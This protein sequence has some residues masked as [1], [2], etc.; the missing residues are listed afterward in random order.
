MSISSP[1]IGSNLDVNGIVS[2]LMSVESQP[3]TLLDQK[4]ASYQSELSAYG[5]LRGAL[6]SFQASLASLNNTSSYNSLSS[7]VA[8]PTVLTATASSTA[9]VGTNSIQVN[10]L[11]Q[12]QKIL[13]TGYSTTSAT[14]GTGTLTFQFGT[15]AG[16]TLT[17]GV[18]TG[19]SFTLNA[20]K[21]S[22]AVTIDSAHNTLSGIRDAVNAAN[23]GVSASIINDG[24][25][26]GNRLV[27]TSNDSGAANSLKISTTDPSLSPVFA[28]D[29]AG[30][31]NMTQTVIAQD[32]SLVVDGV[33][34]TKSSNTIT[35]A[36]QGVTLNLLKTN[37]GTPTTLTTSRSTSAISK[38]VQSFVD[39]Y[40]A[41]NKT[42]SGLTSYD[43][44]T[45]QGGV[46]LGDFT[47]QQIQRQVRLTLSN[48]VKD[49]NGASTN[50]STIGVSFQ[51][52]GSLS[53][54]S[55]KLQNA[56]TTNP[57]SITALFTSF[58]KSTDSLVS[59]TGST[60]NTTP[61][62]Y[63]LN[64][65]QI[66]TQGANAAS[67]LPSLNIFAAGTAVGSQAYGTLTISAGVN[68]TLNVNVDGVAATATIAASAYATPAA[69][70]TA[71]QSAINT[72]TG[73]SVTVTQ[74]NGIFA[75]QSNSVG[76]TASITSTT[77]GST[78]LLGTPT[79]GNNTLNVTL[80]NL[81]GAVTLASGTYTSSAAL[82]AEVQSKINGV[83]AFSTAGSSVAVTVDGFGK[84]T[85]TSNRYGSASNVSLSGSGYTDLLG[86]APTAS[87]GVDVAGTIGGLAASGS[88]QTLTG[89]A[90]GVDGLAIKISGGATG[91]RGN[92]AF[93]Q[94]YAY[95]LNNLLTALQA[96]TGPLTS[97][98]DGLNVTLQDI[99]KQ[100]TDMQA[101]LT[102]TEARYRAQYTAL[103]TL[104]GSLST[105]S[106]FLTQQLANLPKITG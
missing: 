106:T 76:G 97:R 45:K 62:N 36:I 91:A 92:V 72:A 29:P 17:A 5:V 101:Q 37:I 33:T 88:G 8:D 54:D 7:S 99:A 27:F 59:Y 58:G 41:L 3:L 4:T 56:I 105:T 1:G 96:G 38:A 47:A 104:M 73:K 71:V 40:N 83:A 103:D 21:A 64:I 14:I 10:A 49:L 100:K 65:T 46:L 12:A 20:N 22:Q 87:V 67:A 18:Y 94:G 30:T 48:P 93:T 9:S 81:S 43:P 69:L 77:P 13:T 60:A 44:S 102:A 34:I 15:I 70:A 86:T 74:S 23:I 57:D 80:D 95:N 19:A 52:D 31:Q 85:I 24:T 53:L 50:L 63:A 28:Y 75:I 55:T 89:S 90:G 68:D 98:T 25:T 11:A 16:G 39:G 2:K 78:N 35:D 66:A 42:I 61:G 26:N 51:K 84:L 6:A 32:A 82:A 79:D